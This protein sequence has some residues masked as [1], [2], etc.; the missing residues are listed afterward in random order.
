MEFLE[1]F[2]IDSRNLRDSRYFEF[3]TSF[4]EVPHEVGEISQMCL[5]TVSVVFRHRVFQR[6]KL[7]HI[8]DMGCMS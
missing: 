5:V 1:C 4:H 7:C 6:A 2:S 8:W 3:L